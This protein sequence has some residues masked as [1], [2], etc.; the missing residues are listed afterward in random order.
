MKLPLVLFT[1]TLFGMLSQ[2]RAQDSLLPASPSPKNPPQENV[3]PQLL[4]TPD[5]APP[6]PKTE[7]LSIPSAPSALKKG[8]AEELRQAIQIRELKTVVQEDPEVQKQKSMAACAKTEEGRRVLMRNYY[9]LLYT[10]ME[11]MDASLSPVLE[12]QLHAILLGYEQHKVCPSVLVEPVVALPG[13][14]SADHGDSTQ[15]PATPPKKP[16]TQKKKFGFFALP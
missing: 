13:S 5:L 2:I 16:N 8:T 3:T 14:N 7:P 10:K 1:A 6:I 9:T 15:E 4:Q 12:K 11:K